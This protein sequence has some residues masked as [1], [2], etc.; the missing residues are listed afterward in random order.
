MA[1]ESGLISSNAYLE[2]VPEVEA[3][4]RF[5]DSNSLRRTLRA[6]C[7]TTRDRDQLSD[8]T[9]L[10]TE[11]PPESFIIDSDKE[12]SPIPKSY[13]AL[14]LED[15]RIL[16]LVMRG[17]PHEVASRHFE[18]KLGIRINDMNCLEEIILTGGATRSLHGVK[19]EP[20]GSWGPIDKEY[21][22]CVLESGVSESNRALQHDARIWLEREESHVSQVVT[23]RIHRVR[24]E[25]VFSVWKATVPTEEER[26]ARRRSVRKQE[27]HVTLTHG[28]PTAD[29]RLCLSFEELFERRPRP[30]TRECDIVFSPGELE[31]I[32]EVVWEEMDL[33]S[34]DNHR[35]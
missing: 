27:V 14:Y 30:V 34:D 26:T 4:F 8:K 3:T 2:D 5:T 32:A 18:A 12:E 33:Y 28:R 22:T 6:F 11:F 29:G 23:I 35:L 10:V 19:K 31:G 9:V 21:S 16:V 25:I 17:L 1:S 13:K 7:D 24:P 15:V 20:D